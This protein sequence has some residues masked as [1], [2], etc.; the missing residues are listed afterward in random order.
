MGCE[1]TFLETE[2]CTKVCNTCGLEKPAPIIPCEG[3]T[4]NVPL[5]SGYSRHHRL[6]TLLKQLFNPRHYGSPNSEVVA[7]TIKHGPFKHGAELLAWLS[8][9]KVKHKQ[10]QNA[11][12][13]YAIASPDYVIPDPQC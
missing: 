12:Y 9:L 1:H 11:H 6:Y 13:Y 3:Y 4:S 8:K 7:H 5:S 10:Y 2:Y